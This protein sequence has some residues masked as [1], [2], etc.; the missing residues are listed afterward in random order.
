MLYSLLLVLHS[1]LRWVVVFAGVATVARSALA[2]ATGGDWEPLDQ[3]LGRG[4][5]AALDSQVLV[6][7]VLYVISPMTP[8][9][10]DD[11]HTAMAIAPLRFFAVEHAT[12]MI[13]GLAAAHV[14]WVR[15]KKA[16]DDKA[17]HRRVAIGF[18]IALLLIAAGIPWPGLA[19][20]RPLVRG[21]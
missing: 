5:V 8:K 12:S 17:R 20:G 16:P 7:L 10:G 3:K 14:A 21:F 4:F 11:F 13:L 15:A 19:Y 6:G 9:S 2:S 18:G 1:W